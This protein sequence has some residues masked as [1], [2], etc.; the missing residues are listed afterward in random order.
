MSVSVFGFD[1]FPNRMSCG[2]MSLWLRKC[3]FVF[4]IFR[5]LEGMRRRIGGNVRGLV[6]V[7]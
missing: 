2:E 1:S 7:R 4:P 6:W 3:S 5:R